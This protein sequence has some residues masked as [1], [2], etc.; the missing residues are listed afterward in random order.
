MMFHSPSVWLLLLLLLLPLMWWR[1]RRRPALVFSST[2]AARRI[3]PSLALRLRGIVPVLRVLA[4]A[5]LIIALARPQKPN[6]QSRV[7]TEG[8]AIQLILDRSGSMRAMDFQL[9]GEPADRMAASKRVIHEFIEG[10]GELTGRPNDLIG[11][12]G[13]A[14]FA[15]SLCPPTLDHSHVLKTLEQTRFVV[16]R[17]EDGTAIGDALALGVERLHQLTDK[18]R[19]RGA[20]PPESNVIILLTD[21]ENNIGDIEPLTAAEMAAA[22]GIRVYT[23]GAGTREGLAQV[24]V[25]MP[26]GT[27]VMRGVPVSI[28][29]RTLKAIADRTGARYFRA[30]DTDSLIEIYKEIDRLE[31]ARIEETRYVQYEEPA[32]EPF[33]F[34][35]VNLPPILLIVFGLL[36]V[37]TLMSTTRWRMLP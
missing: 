3:R 6:E 12:I 4:I 17:S 5:L 25:P 13:F 9:D 7:V 21:G 15:D 31:R 1:A 37:E 19:D 10:K 27:M 18:A 26:D 32:V 11:L 34:L 16:Q 36:L 28:D 2:A 8:I 35:G 14:R 23:I 30:T 20:R 29:E 22:F 24:P 33:T